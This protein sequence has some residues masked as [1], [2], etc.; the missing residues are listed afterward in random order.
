[1]A[2]ERARG[3]TASLSEAGQ[4]FVAGWGG[5]PGT[6]FADYFA[7]VDKKNKIYQK[8]KSAA[9]L[10]T[11]FGGIDYSIRGKGAKTA[12]QAQ[13]VSTAKKEADRGLPGR[14]FPAG[15]RVMARGQ[16]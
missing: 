11:H 7:P 3:G 13:P 12:R 6:L 16:I 15:M 4:L 14:F 8:K 1:M 2:E 9:R 10:L 5:E